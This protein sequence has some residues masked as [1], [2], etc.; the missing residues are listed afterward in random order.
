MAKILFSFLLGLALSGCGQSPSEPVTLRFS[1]SWNE[2][3]PEIRSQ[4]QQFTSK[5]GIRVKNNPIPQ[6]T[7]EYVELAR[8]LLTD[9]SGTDVVN[10]DLIWSPL[11]APDLIDLRPYLAPEIAQLEPQL[12]PGYTVNGK[13]V[14]VPFIVTLA[15]IEYRPDLLREYGYDHPPQTWTELETMAERIQRGERAKGRKDFWGYVWQGAALSESLACNALEWQASSG[16]GRIIEPDGTVSVN[17]PQAIEAW[18]RARHWIGWISPPSVLAYR[19]Y[20]SILIF[21]S[22]MAAFGRTWLTIPVSRIGQARQ[23]GKRSW[24]SVVE[25][26]FSRMPAGSAGSVG[27]LGGAGTAISVHSTHRAEAIALVRYLLSAQMQAGENGGPDTGWMRTEFPERPAFLER[28]ESSP[29]ASR[30]PVFIARPSVAAGSMYRQVSQAYVNA[31]HSVLAGQV[32]A[33]EAAA[34]LEKQLIAITGFHRGPPPT[35][36]QTMR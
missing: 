16:G 27:T 28:D 23:I 15:S 11:L 26:G 30:T 29:G 14:A 17:N 32:G 13:L 34:A 22:G 2:N 20:D 12:L 33:P 36:K 4:L 21:D 24:P 8:K 5:T 1:Y 10:I 6:G 31:V 3:G 7:R 9:S 35:E 18:Q 25:T 19:E